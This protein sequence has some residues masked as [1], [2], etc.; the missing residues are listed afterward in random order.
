MQWSGPNIQLQ[1]C[2]CNKNEKKLNYLVKPHERFPYGFLFIV[3]AFF[4][5]NPICNTVEASFFKHMAFFMFSLLF[6]KKS[7]HQKV[8]KRFFQVLSVGLCEKHSF[9]II[10]HQKRGL[11]FNFWLFAWFCLCWPCASFCQSALWR[12]I[13]KE[14]NSIYN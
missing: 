5:K 1:S 7:F 10:F 4:G 6:T 13:S 8:L 2:Q 9:S 11:Y 14:N 12:Y 3:M